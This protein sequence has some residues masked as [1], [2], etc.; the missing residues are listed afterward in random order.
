MKQRLKYCLALMRNP[1]LLLLDEPMSN[2]DDRGK[3]LVDGIIKT[4]KGILVIA[5]NERSELEYGSQI[6]RLDR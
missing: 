4:H 1:S 3:E 6:I 2:L 5:T